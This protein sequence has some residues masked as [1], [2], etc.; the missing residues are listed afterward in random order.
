MYASGHFVH[1]KLLNKIKIVLLVVFYDV[2]IHLVPLINN[3]EVTSVREDKRSIGAY[4]HSHDQNNFTLDCYISSSNSNPKSPI[5]LIP[6]NHCSQPSHN[7]TSKISAKQNIRK[8]KLD[9][10]RPTPT[11]VARFALRG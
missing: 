9:A 6:R 11:R 1:N 3:Q 8:V 10:R 2:I 4:D 7:N 5:A